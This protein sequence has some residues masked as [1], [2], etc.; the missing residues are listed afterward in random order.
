MLSNV[1]HSM[2]GFVGEHTCLGGQS[3]GK[4]W[5]FTGLLMIR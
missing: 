5:C 3:R 4:E 2:L 1:F